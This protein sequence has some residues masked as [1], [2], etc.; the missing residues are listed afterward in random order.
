MLGDALGNLNCPRR[1]ALDAVLTEMHEG[2]RGVV[3][4]YRNDAQEFACCAD[5]AARPPDRLDE[6]TAAPFRDILETLA[7]RA[8]RILGSPPGEEEIVALGFSDAAINGE[9]E[10]E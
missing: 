8:P 9:G 1:R 3:V 10:S 4:Y 6:A 2:G 5:P 7:L